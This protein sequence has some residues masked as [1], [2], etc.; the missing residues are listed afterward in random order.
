MRA[1]AI[2]T[3]SDPAGELDQLWISASYGGAWHV[4]RLDQFRQE[5]DP[6]DPVMTDLSATFI[7]GAGTVFG[8]IP[9]L[10][11]RTVDVAADAAVYTD[12]VVSAAGMVTIANPAARVSIGL[13]FPARLTTLR[14]TAGSE[15][16]DSIGKK[17]RI[18]RL[19][20]DVLNTRGLR[21]TVQGNA[22]RDI[23]QLLGDSIANEGLAPVSGVLIAEDCGTYDR[24]GQVTIERVVPTGATIRA[25]QP[26][27]DMR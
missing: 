8:P 4:L 17:R 19:A 13:R 2:A 25:I 1:R 7:G 21:I 10:A 18:G 6:D 20:I 23:E 26:T 3:I 24:A 15:N 14:P 27:V 12:Q 5:D 11:G 22:P 16:G 9:W